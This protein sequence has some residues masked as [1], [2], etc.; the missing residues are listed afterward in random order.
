MK[1]T[2]S[3][4]ITFV[5]ENDVKFIRLAFCDIFGAQKNISIMPSELERALEGGVSFD[6]A[7]IRGF[8]SDTSD[9]MLKPDPGTLSVLPWRPSQGRVIRFFCNVITPKGG[10]FSGDTRALLSREVERAQ[11][12]GLT[13]R[14]GPECE[15]YL[16]RLDEDGDPTLIP[17]DRG[18]YADVAP[19]DRGENVRREICLTL[20]EMGIAPEASHHEQGPGQNEIDFRY[21]G[22]LTAAD[23]LITLRTVV[24]NIAARN[25]LY[26]SF[27]PK[28]LPDVSGSGLHVNLS[29]AKN[30]LNIFRNGPFEHSKDAE[31]FIAGVLARARETAAFLTPLTNSYRRLGVL[32]APSHVAWAHGMRDE[33][34]RIPAAEGEYA[35][36]ELRSPD[37]AMNPYLGFALILRAGLDG[38]EAGLPLPAPSSGEEYLPKTLDEALTIA[39]ESA[40]VK[41]AIP[42]DVLAEYLAAK[43]REAA[44]IL[45]AAD[46]EAAE[47]TLYFEEV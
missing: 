36:M 25:G 8:R 5:R 37:P 46:P 41:S 3:E 38:I 24:K 31:S 42:S 45:A 14:I 35:R 27:M 4:V 20:E 43:R 34:I 44:D 30:G 26:A 22:A 6:A 19:K 1:T 40:F 13:C 32:E 28:P 47:R 23:N 16:F 17:H 39:E 10:P 2:A 7:A 21:S 29:L 18:G 15:F 11:R 33:L 9:L 12:M